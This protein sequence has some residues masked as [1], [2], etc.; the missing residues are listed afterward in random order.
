MS[1]H[2]LRAATAT[3]AAALCLAAVAGPAAAQF[4]GTNGR[5]LFQRD[6]GLYTANPD[7]SHE[8]F[9]VAGGFG[10]WSPDG[11]QIAYQKATDPDPNDNQEVQ[12]IYVARPDGSD[13][14]QLT[15]PI[16]DSEK[17]SWSRDGRWIIFSTDA[18]DYP[19]GQGIYIVPSD[20][21]A[22]MRMLTPKPAG[23]FFAELPRYS[24]DGSKFVFTA[25]RGA[26]SVQN[27]HQDKLAGFASAL[28][29][30]K[31]DGS[32]VRQLTAWGLNAVGPDWSPDGR[33]IAFESRPPHI[34]DVGEVMVIGADGKNPR[35]LTDDHGLTGLSKVDRSVRYEESFNPTFSPD[36]RQIIY[37]HASFKASEGFHLGLAIMNADGTGR[38]WVRDGTGSEHRPEWGTA[39]LLP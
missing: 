22:P 35:T 5:I 36:G 16:G 30:A 34:G 28:F 15:P 2:A 29:V 33:T 1:R 20:G 9:V 7:L 23:T 13:E 10:N 24:P 6:D 8:T 18:G 25:Y 21:S 14:R 37:V 12:N 11:T 39:P 19:D 31:A 38:R 4:P 3:F 32:G 27:A 26:N 17:P